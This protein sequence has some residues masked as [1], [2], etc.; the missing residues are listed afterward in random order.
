MR[1]QAVD[2]CIVAACEVA[3]VGPLDLDDARPEVG[4]VARGER[5]RD[6]L[7]DGDDGDVFK[8]KH[9]LIAWGIHTR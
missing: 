2:R 6:R 9:F 3:A 4:E 7:L 1:R 8:R 5:R